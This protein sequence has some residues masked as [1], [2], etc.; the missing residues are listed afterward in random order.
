[1]T[2]QDIFI[3]NQALDCV[4]DFCDEELRQDIVDAKT[5]IE[6]EVTHC[7]VR[8][9]ADGKLEVRE[10]TKTRGLCVEYDV[11]LIDTEEDCTWELNQRNR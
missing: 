1:M 4:I 7:L 2:S 9:N 5:A 3:I 11:L 10:L 6:N 8:Y